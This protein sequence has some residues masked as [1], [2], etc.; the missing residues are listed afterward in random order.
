MPYVHEW[1]DSFDSYGAGASADL[2]P[3]AYSAVSG[4]TISFPAGSTG[5]CLKIAATLAAPYFEKTLS[6]SYSGLCVAF[7][8]KW[9]GFPDGFIF[10]YNGSTQQ[11]RIEFTSATNMRVLRGDGTTLGNVTVPSITTGTWYHFEIKVIFDD[12]AGAVT[13]RF[14]GSQVGALTGLDTNNGGSNLANKIR[15]GYLGNTNDA[16]YW[17]DLI[18]QPSTGQFPLGPVEVHRIAP[19]GSGNSNQFATNA[20]VGDA[21]NY[22]KVDDT[23]SNQDSDYVESDNLGDKDTY[24]MGNLTPTSGAIVAVVAHS[25]AKLDVA[26]AKALKHVLRVGG[27]DYSSSSKTLTTSY[28]NYQSAWEENPAGGGWTIAA[29]NGLEAGVEVG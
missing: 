10:F 3:E 4:T 29:V 23:P 6:Q 9:D 24:A 13:I 1:V 5:N 28:A 19:S 11:L 16:Y 17:D 27:V 15:W 8:M 7:R 20:G 2:T 18:I 14:N 22:Q 21:N 25:Q 26:S 12:S